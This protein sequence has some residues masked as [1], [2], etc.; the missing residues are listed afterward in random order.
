M[1]SLKFIGRY[2]GSNFFI[3]AKIELKYSSVSPDEIALCQ[4]A[5]KA[6]FEFLQR[7]N[8]EI[9]ISENKRKCCY[10]VLNIL[11]FSSAR[12][13]MSV[14]VKTPDSNYFFLLKFFLIFKL[15]KT[16]IKSFCLVK[17]QIP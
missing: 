14:I 10:K 12:A 2:N 6:H 5:K 13:R 11:P 16:Q 1:V 4:A 3:F 8:D 9:T 7:D 15:F 17:E